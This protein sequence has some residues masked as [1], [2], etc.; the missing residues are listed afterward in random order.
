V[1]R[2]LAGS[3]AS[4]NA[5]STTEAGSAD[6]PP[7]IRPNAVAVV[8][9]HAGGI[10]EDRPEIADSVR[11]AILAELEKQIT[12]KG[13]AACCAT[14]P[15]S[16][17]ADVAMLERAT[18]LVDAVHHSIL[19]HHYQYGKAR[20]FDYTVGETIARLRTSS[21][22]AVLCVYLQAAVPTGSR[23]ALQ[24]TA[25]VVGV[26]VAGIPICVSGSQVDLTLML[27]DSQT[28]DVLWYDRYATEADVRKERTIRD[29]VKHIIK[30]FLEPRRK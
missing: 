25:A 2:L 6:V 8:S 27:I 14:T 5:R 19:T 15:A 22:D 10:T 4:G 12:E 26:L 1:R 18:S 30:H 16:A 23:K 24:V 21:C 20:Q 29:V 13:V 7:A 9:L 17:A 3:D 28:G 11:A